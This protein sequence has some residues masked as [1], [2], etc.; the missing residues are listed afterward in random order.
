MKA[1]QS[2]AQTTNKKGSTSPVSQESSRAQ[3]GEIARETGD[4]PHRPGG[5]RV[6]VRLGDST[7]EPSGWLRGKSLVDPFLIPEHGMPLSVIKRRA[8]KNHLRSYLRHALEKRVGV[9]L[10]RLEHAFGDGW[11]AGDHD[12]GCL[13]PPRD[14]TRLQLEKL[15][16]GIPAG[17]LRGL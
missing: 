6:R 16:P 1:M 3:G 4:S 11:G 8:Y 5:G 7:R 12:S 15:L 9:N 2:T 17:V 10:V 13:L 14:T